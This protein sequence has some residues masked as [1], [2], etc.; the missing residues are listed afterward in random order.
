[1]NDKANKKQQNFINLL[2]ALFLYLVLFSLYIEASPSI[3]NVWFRN[4]VNNDKKIQ[5]KGLISVIISPL[6][7]KELW[8]P[9][10][11]DINFFIGVIIVSLLVFLF[12]DH[13]Q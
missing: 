10:N 12:T 8:L 7:V 9:K 4:D 6:K 13:N 2:K 3:G 5:I 1:M 11:W